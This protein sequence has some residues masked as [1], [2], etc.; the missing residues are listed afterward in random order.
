[1]TD[2]DLY[3]LQRRGPGVKGEAD[4]AMIVGAISEA[5]ARVAAYERSKDV[6]WASD[7]HTACQQIVTDAGVIH[8]IYAGSHA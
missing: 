2:L 1:M 6:A 3:L 4:R 7:S 8:T 5:H